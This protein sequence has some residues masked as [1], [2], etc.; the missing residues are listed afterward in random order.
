MKTAVFASLMLLATPAFA[1]QSVPQIAFDSVPDYPNLPKGM[2]F[3][4]VPGVAVNSKGSVFIFTRSNSA[5][6]PAYAP[7][8][9]QFGR[10]TNVELVRTQQQPSTGIGAGA[11]VGGVV[12]GVV[13]HQVGRGT[14]RD[15]AT[16]VGALG[17]A[18]VGNAIEK[19]RTPPTVPEVYRVTVQQD[20]GT[21]R[22]FDYATQPNA[23]IGD[24]VRVENNQVYR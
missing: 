21:V 16:V 17:G 12:G 4:E 18:L 2:N 3:G 19:G 11:V 24:R 22:T 13:G 10:V 6:G 1:Q 8:A 9:A 7:A 23:R 14:G 5:N 15:I 20:D